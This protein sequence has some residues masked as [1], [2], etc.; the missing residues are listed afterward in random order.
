MYEKNIYV[1]RGGQIIQFYMKLTINNYLQI[2]PLL[3]DMI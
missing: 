2:F 1:V 3:F